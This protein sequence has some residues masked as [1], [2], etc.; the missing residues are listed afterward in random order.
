M[1]A[2]ELA[3]SA[4]N[5]AT[6][7]PGISPALRALWLARAGNWEAAHDLCQDIPGKTGSWI[8]AWLHREEGDQFNAEYWYGRAGKPVPPRTMPLAEEW[9]KIADAL[10]GD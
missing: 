7:P 4:A 2:A 10:S 5:D 1:N 3:Q 9:M 8:H 6:P